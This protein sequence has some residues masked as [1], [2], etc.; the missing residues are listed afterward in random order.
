MIGGAYSLRSCARPDVTLVTCGAMATEAIGASERLTQ[1][2]VAVEVV[3]VTSPSLLFDAVRSR[4][5]AGDS[6]TF[7]PHRAAPMV[8]VL[9]GHPHALAFLSGIN[10]VRSKYLG[11]S[12]FGQ[13]G[14]LDE[15]YRYHGIDADGIVRAALDLTG[16]S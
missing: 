7:P 1:L 4:Q 3:C 13:S 14:S 2:G 10:Q 15:V 9:D 11:V 5:G 16:G 12:G 6:P 8:T